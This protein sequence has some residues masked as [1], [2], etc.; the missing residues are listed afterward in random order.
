MQ[1]IRDLER[2][3][4]LLEP[5]GASL[6]REVQQQFEA[7][8]A[9]IPQLLTADIPSILAQYEVVPSIP[10][11]ANYQSAAVE[12]ERTLAAY[13]A[14]GLPAV[15]ALAFHLREAASTVSA[16]KALQ[17]MFAG[18]L[19]ERLRKVAITSEEE[20]SARVD[21]LAGFIEQRLAQSQKGPMSTEGYIQIM[22]AI[23]FF[24]N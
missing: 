15:D 9:L 21:V 24:I 8:K 16:A 14:A 13:S 5:P 19:F 20:A 18:S 23:L 11:L 22:M 7:T 17:Q 1:A 12:V 2:Y 6:L 3:K 4:L 10:M